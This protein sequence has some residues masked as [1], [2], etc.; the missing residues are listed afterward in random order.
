MA[1][2]DR[3]LRS[4]ML[5]ASFQLSLANFKPTFIIS[6]SNK[7]NNCV[8]EDEWV[9]PTGVILNLP[10]YKEGRHKMGMGKLLIETSNVCT[11]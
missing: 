5:H 2:Y 8:Q 10:E 7:I 9:E 1:Q 6:N 4:S 11:K 3:L